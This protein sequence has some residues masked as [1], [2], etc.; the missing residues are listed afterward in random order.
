[1][2]LLAAGLVG[3]AAATAAAGGYPTVAPGFAAAVT[4]FVA[5]VAAFEAGRRVGR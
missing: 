4:L 5:S 1:L 3:V 2:G